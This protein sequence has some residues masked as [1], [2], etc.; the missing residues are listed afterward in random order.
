VPLEFSSLAVPLAVASPHFGK[1][2]ALVGNILF[3]KAEFDRLVVF[4]HW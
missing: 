2:F 3:E 4:S 1:E